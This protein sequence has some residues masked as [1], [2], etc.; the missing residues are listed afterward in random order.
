M[1]YLN[2]L[3]EVY[4]TV[5]LLECGPFD[6]SAPKSREKTAKVRRFDFGTFSWRSTALLPF[7]TD[8]DLKFKKKMSF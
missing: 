8:F 3:Y 2:S 5:L 7:A 6:I 4:A 1:N